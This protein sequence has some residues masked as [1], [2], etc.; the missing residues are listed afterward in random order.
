MMYNEHLLYVCGQSRPNIKLSSAAISAALVL[1]GG[2][3]WIWQD[4]PI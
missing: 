3:L 4:F 1:D 2:V